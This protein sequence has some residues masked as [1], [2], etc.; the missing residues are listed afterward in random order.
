[1]GLL[2]VDHLSVV[3]DGAQDTVRTA[4]STLNPDAIRPEICAAHPE[5]RSIA[6]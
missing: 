6:A 2:V 3:L 4:I 5:G 1:M